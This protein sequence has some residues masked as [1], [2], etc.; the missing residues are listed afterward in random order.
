MLSLPQG[1]VDEGPQAL[2]A[3]PGRS[4]LRMLTP[5]SSRVLCAEY[6]AFSGRRMP[7][8]RLAAA[9]G[10]LRTDPLSQVRELGLTA[11]GQEPIAGRDKQHKDVMISRS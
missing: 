7:E 1:G 10:L 9:Q 4:L 8:E 6:D 2:R 5:R 3:L 11:Y